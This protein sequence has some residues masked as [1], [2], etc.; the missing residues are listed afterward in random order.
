MKKRVL[1]AAGLAAALISGGALALAQAPPQGPGPRMHGGGPGGPG[2][3]GPRDFGLRGIELTDAQRDQVKSIMDS[4]KD[5][6]RQLGE[7]MRQAHEAFAQATQA[8]TVDEAT[9]RARSTAVASA[10][11]DEA[12]LRAKV[13][14]EVNAILTP[15]QLEQL[16][17]RQEQRANRRPRG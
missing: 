4:H 15:E 2:F 14:S 11:A 8:E 9:I 10:M 7:K 5:E 3:G 17:T 16:K 6:F 1:I 12:I 13:R